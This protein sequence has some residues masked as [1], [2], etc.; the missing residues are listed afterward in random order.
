VIAAVPST[1]Q[2]ETEI[3]GRDIIYLKSAPAVW[4]KNSSTPWFQTLPFYIALA[5]PALLLLMVVGITAN[6]DALAN[7]VARARRQQAPKAARQNVQRAEQAMRRNDEGAFYEALWNALAD[8]FGHRLNLAAGEV[9]LSVV[10]SRISQEKEELEMLFNTIEQRRYGFHGGELSK[11]E[12]KHLL[13]QLTV[14]LKKCER[15]K[16]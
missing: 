11:G 5:F 14:T 12:M 6:R 10:L 8:Y 2:P 3:L 15:I 4:N 13:R 1:I 16:L 9:S 7:D